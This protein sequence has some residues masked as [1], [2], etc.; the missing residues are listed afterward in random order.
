MPEISK[1]ADQA[2]ALLLNVAE[3]GPGTTAELAERLGYHRTV[4]HRLLATLEGR[5]FVRR[6][7]DGYGL[8]TV[9]RRLADS[10][11]ADLL[12]TARPVMAELGAATGETITLHVREG[13]EIVVAERVLGTR[14]LVKV[15]YQPGHRRPLALGAAGRV[16]LAHLGPSPVPVDDP[17]RLAEIRRAGHDYSHDELR[18]GVSGVAAPVFS[19]LG[20][21]AALSVVVPVSRDGDL[22]RWLP[23]LTT[24]AREITACLGGH[25]APPAG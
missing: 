25:P 11:E 10:V 15:D 20:I 18:A 3:Q 4:T 7:P 13:T 17:A 21:Q 19:Q 9:L 8:G 24:A 16:I 12:T 1:T 2:L 14:H 22:S 6:R 5:G 23:A